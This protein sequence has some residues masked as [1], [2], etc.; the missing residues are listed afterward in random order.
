MGSALAGSA[1]LI[2][3][4][5]RHRKLFGGGMRQAGIIA[6]GALH[7]LECHRD[8]LAHDHQH[9]QL[10]ARAVRNCSSLELQPDE[11]DTNI[12]IF[13]VDPSLGTAGQFAAALKQRGVWTLGVGAQL[14]RIVTHLDVSREDAEAA[15]EIIPQVADALASGSIELPPDEPTY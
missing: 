15:A 11:V 5:R 10:I 2:A 12:V 8:R 6:A 3:E 4:A 9:A 7:A 1:E 13:R 14:V